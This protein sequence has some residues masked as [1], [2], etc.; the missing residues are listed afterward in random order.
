M[1]FTEYKKWTFEQY[2]N[3]FAVI[4]EFYRIQE[5]DV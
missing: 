3:K 5:M 2:I 4:N 1:N